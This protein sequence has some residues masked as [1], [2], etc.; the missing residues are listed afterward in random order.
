MKPQDIVFFIVFAILI[1]KRSMKLAAA[2][3]I[4]C[5][6]LSIPLFAKWVF[7][8]AERLVWYSVGFFLLAII[9][10]LIQTKKNK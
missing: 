9:L 2:I 3:G 7:F 1:W 6:A 10:S 4:A 8:T 5:L